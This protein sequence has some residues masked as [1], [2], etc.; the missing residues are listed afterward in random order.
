[1]T[2][3][4]HPTTA[5]EALTSRL[6]NAAGGRTIAF[7][8]L[9]VTDGTNGRLRVTLATSDLPTHSSFTRSSPFAARE[10]TLPSMSHSTTSTSE[11]TQQAQ[12]WYQMSSPAVGVAPR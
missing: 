5:L 1:L 6:F 8:V 9:R 10:T 3:A 11:E 7:G 12:P 4:V 2:L